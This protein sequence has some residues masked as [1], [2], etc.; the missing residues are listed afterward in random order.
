MSDTPCRLSEYD[1]HTEC[2]PPPQYTDGSTVQP[3]DS[4]RYHQAPGGLLPPEPGW[5]YGTAEVSTHCSGTLD[6]AATDGHTY[7]LLGHVIERVTPEE[8]A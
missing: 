8:I 6:L 2:D 7:G 1:W 4:V 5:K 3:G